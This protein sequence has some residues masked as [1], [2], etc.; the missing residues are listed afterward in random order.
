MRT[1]KVLSVFILL[2]AIGAFAKEKPAPQDKT[3]ECLS[4]H[5]DASL[6]KD[7]DGKPVSLHVDEGKFKNSLHGSMFGCTDCHTDVKGFPHDPAPAK[8]DC[9]TCHADQVA[10]YKASVHGEA[11]AKGNK[12][13][14]TC[15]SCHGSLHE[16]VPASDPKSPVAHQNIPKTCGT[17]H[18]Q[19]FVMESSGRSSAPFFSYEESVHGKA[20]SAGS[21]KA[22]VCT[23]CHGAH[24]VLNAANPKSSIFKFNVP[25]TCGKCHENVKT[26]FMGSIHGQAI[27]KGVSSSP[28]CTDCHGIHGIKSHIDPNSSVSAQNLARTTCAKCHEGVRLSED[29]GIAGGRASSYN[30]SYH[31]LASKMGSKT[32][33]NCASCHGVHNILPSSDPKSTI[34][35]ANLTATCGQ[36]HP[37]AGDNFVKGK[38]HIQAPLS[39]DV[40]SI[41]VNWT[42]RIYLGFIFGT[43]GFML[44][45]NVLIWRKKAA[46]KRKDP[47]RIVVRMEKEQRIQH[48]ILLVSFITL[49]ITGFALKYPESMF[50]RALL[51][52]EF[53]RSWVHRIAGTT[54]ILVS[55]YHVFYLAAKKSGRQMMMDMLPVPKDAT[56]IVENLRYYLGLGGK[57]AHFHRFT[58]GEK[59]EYWALVWGTFV[60]ASTGLM[61]WFKV[62]FGNLVPR[63]WL[64]VATAIHFYEAILATLAI[65]VWHFYQVIFDPDV[66]PMNWAWYDGKMSVELYSHEHSLDQDTIVASVGKA[67][68]H[69]EGDGEAVI[70][71][72][73]KT[74]KSDAA[75]N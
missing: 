71:S 48:L 44:L 74:G 45:H 36:C 16:V 63:W 18:G 13:A 26:E 55:V 67:A 7:V 33:A 60:M 50:S 46:A 68:E 11:L 9:S 56:D 39:A 24:E 69:A 47:R 75:H 37:G 20:V 23:D 8:V 12:Q 29:F 28:V 52:G 40:G 70:A 22:A 38:I 31:G 6:A 49:V 32:A 10:G 5:S 17:C 3:A 53:V 4:C 21:G 42:R 62:G 27:T 14:A 35:Q 64:D 61:L 73:S 58:Y 2:F 25:N 43:I 30:A 65:V 72:D 66:Y 54:L 59:M 51:M 19:K 1:A 34:A 15:V 41:A 57:P